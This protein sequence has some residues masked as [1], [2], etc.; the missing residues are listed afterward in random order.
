MTHREALVVY[1]PATML[2]ATVRHANLNQVTICCLSLPLTLFAVTR[3]SALVFDHPLSSY[4]LRVV[5]FVL[6]ISLE[7]HLHVLMC[8]VSDHPPLCTVTEHISA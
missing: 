6:I 8:S 2:P 3:V 1:N 5:V 7:R 4:V